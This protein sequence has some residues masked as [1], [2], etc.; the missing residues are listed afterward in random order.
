MRLDNR[1]IAPAFGIGTLVVLL[2]VIGFVLGAVFGAPS[3]LAIIGV[4]LLIAPF[5]LL[6]IGAKA[7]QGGSTAKGIFAIIVAL[8]LFGIFVTVGIGLILF[9]F[10]AV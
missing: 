1:A 10:I 5:A 6:W 9:A 4:G 7:I 2:I 8:L 3:G